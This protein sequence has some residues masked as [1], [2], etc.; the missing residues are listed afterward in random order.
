MTANAAIIAPTELKFE[1]TDT[2]FYV[3]VVY[4][5]KKKKI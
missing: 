3:P 1:T 5:S 4:L 2:K